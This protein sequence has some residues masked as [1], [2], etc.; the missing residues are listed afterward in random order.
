LKVN[1]TINETTGKAWQDALPDVPFF[2][3]RVSELIRDE[4]PEQAII[5]AV[6]AVEHALHTGS[7]E[8][9]EAW[10]ETYDPEWGQS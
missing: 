10:G 6:Y 1:A 4:I 2:V 5:D 9:L 8:R 7:D 3:S